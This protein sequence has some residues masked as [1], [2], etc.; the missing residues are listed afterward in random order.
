MNINDLQNVI[1]LARKG[2]SVIAS[3]LSAQEGASAFSS[4]GEV[5]KFINGLV[6]QQK[7]QMEAQQQ[8]ETHPNVEVIE[9]NQ[10]P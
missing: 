2:L 3:N 1:T 9:V 5:E 6:E 8:L 7:K 10:Q 4:I